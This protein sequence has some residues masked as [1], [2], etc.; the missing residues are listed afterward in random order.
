VVVLTPA[1]GSSCTEAGG[2]DVDVSVDG[3]RLRAAGGSR[4]TSGSKSISCRS[5]LG[6]AQDVEALATCQILNLLL[7]PLDL[8]VLGLR[9]QLN[10]VDLD[11]TGETG[12]GNLLGNLLCGVAGLLDAP[13]LPELNDIIADLIN[14]VLSNLD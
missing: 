2:F 5:S 10:Q 3:G 13:S 7:G 12:P 11:I 1:A 4:P 6:G 9:V 14:L 8:N